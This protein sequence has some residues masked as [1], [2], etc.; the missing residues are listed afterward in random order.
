MRIVVFLA[1][2]ALSA[3]SSAS[4]Y[5]IGVKPYHTRVDGWSIDVYHLE[6]KAQAIRLNVKFVPSEAE[7]ARRSLVAI[8]STTGCSVVA[9]T[10]DGDNSVMNARVRC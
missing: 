1:L 9:G 4:P 7:M 8:E 2:L 10:L 3:C 5:Y 6:H